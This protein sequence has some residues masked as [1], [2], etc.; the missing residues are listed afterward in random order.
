MVAMISKTL[1]LTASVLCF[2]EFV[3]GEEEISI[4]ITESIMYSGSYWNEAYPKQGLD[5]ATCYKSGF[6]KNSFWKAN[7]GRPVTVSKVKITGSYAGSVRVRVG[8]DTEVVGGLKGHDSNRLCRMLEFDGE[9]TS[10][11]FTCDQ[12][13]FGNVIS[14]SGATPGG[15]HVSRLVICDVSVYQ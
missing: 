5:G 4:N 9:M 1:L 11:V 14:V 3:Y 8:T 2:L 7:I 10:R 15:D 12:P 6:E 13:R